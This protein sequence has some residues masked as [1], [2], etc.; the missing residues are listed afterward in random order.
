MDQ[1]EIVAKLK[2]FR[3]EFERDGADIIEVVAPVA[4]ILADVCT[5]LGLNTF[6]QVEVLGEE[7]AGAVAE[8]EA[9]RIWEPVEEPIALPHRPV[10]EPAPI[11]A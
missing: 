8:W 4:I 5:A 11:A 10:R 7:A 6:D 1:Q 9:A 2:A 3:E